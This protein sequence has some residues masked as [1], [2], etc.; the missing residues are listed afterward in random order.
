MHDLLTAYLVLRPCLNPWLRLQLWLNHV[1]LITIAATLATAAADAAN[2]PY[3]LTSSSRH[4]RGKTL[5]NKPMQ[6]FVHTAH[7]FDQ[8]KTAFLTLGESALLIQV[9]HRLHKVCSD[10]AQS[11]RPD[12]QIEA[13]Y[14]LRLI[15]DGL[16][17][18]VPWYHP[19]RGEL[20]THLLYRS[21][22]RCSVGHL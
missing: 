19:M 15:N 2:R 20:Q 11:K 16:I 7:R 10:L 13:W 14:L 18:N 6:R 22:G 1:A 4:L 5:Q 3:A 12:G 21:N 9:W 17:V 8:W